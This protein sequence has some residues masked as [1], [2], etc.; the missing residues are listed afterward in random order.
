MFVADDINPSSLFNN[1]VSSLT[2]ISNSFVLVFE[3]FTL[4]TRMHGV[5]S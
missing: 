1:N 5:C 4:S 2:L 3:L